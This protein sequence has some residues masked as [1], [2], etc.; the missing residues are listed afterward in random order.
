MPNKKI[1]QN[2]VTVYWRLKILILMHFKV[3]VLRFKSDTGNTTQWQLFNWPI[4]IKGISFLSQFTNN[5][6]YYNAKKKKKPH[7]WL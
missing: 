2:L 7:Q 3:H 5:I 1:E 6:I 4:I